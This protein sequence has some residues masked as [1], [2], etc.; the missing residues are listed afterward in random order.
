MTTEYQAVM[1]AYSAVSVTCLVFISNPSPSCKIVNTCKGISIIY[2][3]VPMFRWISS[4][5]NLVNSWHASAD[6]DGW[7]LDL[8]SALFLATAF[9]PLFAYIT[10]I[11]ATVF[12]PLPFCWCFKLVCV[13]WWLYLVWFYH[14]YLR[15]C[16]IWTCVFN[17][18]SCL[19]E[20]K[21]EKTKPFPYEHFKQAWTR[22]RFSLQL[23]KNEH[24]DLI[25]FFKSER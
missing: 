18:N 14:I 11:L 15:L 1:A 21:A 6:K 9:F 23:C 16:W 22:K 25:N 10:L 17:L 20:L 4:S 3:H 8:I 24:H 19:S 12:F 2:Y 5:K 13:C 7:A